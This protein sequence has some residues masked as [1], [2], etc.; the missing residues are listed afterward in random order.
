MK[1]KIIVP[2][3]ALVLVLAA[4]GNS[5]AS[6]QSKVSSGGQS[7]VSSQPASQ[8][9]SQAAPQSGS[10]S[11]LQLTAEELA[12]YDGQNGNPAY[13]AVDGVIYDVTN[14]PEWRNGK[15]ASGVTAGQDL[16]DA[17][18]NQSPHGLKVLEGLPVVGQLV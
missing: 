18:K 8:V 13:V 7:Q 12:K 9:G 15:H 10:S 3:L 4:C 6:S 1:G 17:I 5:T 16:T 14:A 2:V 11:M